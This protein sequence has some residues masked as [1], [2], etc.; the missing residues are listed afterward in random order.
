MIAI[1][2]LSVVM[3]VALLATAATAQDPFRVS[4]DVDRSR[5][6]KVQLVGQVRNDS[7]SEVFDVNVTAPEICGAAAFAR[8]YATPPFCRIARRCKYTPATSSRVPVRRMS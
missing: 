6:D 1:R 2:A 8:T 4:F 3:G 7:S 5:G